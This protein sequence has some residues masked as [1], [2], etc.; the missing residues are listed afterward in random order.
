MAE[1][2]IQDATLSGIADAIR[3]KTGGTDTIQVSAMAAAIAGIETGGGSG[4]GGGF[5]WFTKYVSSVP[6][7]WG[8]RVSV[9]FGAKPGFI[10]MYPSSSVS[11]DNGNHFLF[12][13]TTDEF[14]AATGAGITTV[15]LRK[16]TNTKKIVRTAVS[17]PID[18]TDVD[19]AIYNADA[20]GFNLGKTPEAGGYYVIA[21]I[22]E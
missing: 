18:S 19:N 6:A 20:T 12:L 22:M 2:K 5:R 10:L 8:T 3:A 14:N 16:N 4:G 17:V 1:Y 15:F 7:T 11:P 9:D 21:I 13:G